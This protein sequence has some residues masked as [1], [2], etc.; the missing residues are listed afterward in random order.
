[1]ECRLIN[2]VAGITLGIH[3]F[4][5]T[6]RSVKEIGIIQWDQETLDMFGAKRGAAMSRAAQSAYRTYTNQ[7]KAAVKNGLA[8]QKTMPGD[9]SGSC[10]A[11][12][13]AP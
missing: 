13:G 3:D 7:V 9:V 5:A 1:M 2:A 8:G 6:R 4:A 11:I 10:S 12:F